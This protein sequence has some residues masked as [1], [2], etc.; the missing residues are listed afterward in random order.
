MEQ[1]RKKI[2]AK[3]ARIGV[4]GLGYVGLPLSL[5]FVRAGYR[6]VGIDSAK[7]K[8]SQ[9]KSGTSYIRPGSQQCCQ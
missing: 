8:I 5:E 6:V 7:E 3:S 4:I 9:L 2:N 1:I